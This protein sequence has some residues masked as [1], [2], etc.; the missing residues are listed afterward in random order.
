LKVAAVQYKPILGDVAANLRKAQVLVREA[1]AKNAKWV[2]LPEFFTSANGMHENIEKAHRPLNGEPMEFLK[3]LAREGG[4]YVGGS[5]LAEADGDIYNTFVLACP[6]GNTFTHDKD[7][8]STIY[9]SSLY[10]GGEDAEYARWLRKAG[11]DTSGKIIPGRQGNNVRGCFEVGD[12]NIG[13]ALCWELVR[14]RT[15]RRLAGRIDMLLGASGWWWSD[16]EFGWPGD[17]TTD[18]IREH[19]EEQEA[20]IR[21]APRRLARMLGVPVVHANFCGLNRAFLTRELQT[22]VT[23]RY[24]GESQIV[25]GKGRTVARLSDKEGVVVADVIPGRGEPSEPISDTEEW[26]PEMSERAKRLWNETGAEG[27]D[28]YL[29]HVRPHLRT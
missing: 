2:V 14:Y 12:L 15:A 18:E 19:R 29:E 16:P 13:A 27:R 24:L 28:Y 6:D 5:F 11:V 7:F 3:R 20:L 9:E 25:D 1:F 23:G 21:E 26:M 4:A 17:R 10:A 22:P 8:P